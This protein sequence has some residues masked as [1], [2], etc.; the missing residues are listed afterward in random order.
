MQA[1]LTATKRRVGTA[2]RSGIVFL[3]PALFSACGAAKLGGSGSSQGTVALVVENRGFADVN[4]YVVRSEGARGVRLGTVNGGATVT[5]K[6]R[7]TYLQAGALMQL[8]ARAI[9]GRSSWTS[10]IISVS[11]GGVV[12]LE[13]I[14]TGAT[15][16][17]R[18]QFYII[19]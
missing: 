3:T 8:Q 1:M 13:L 17:S 10:P 4:L 14:A 18:S 15:D 16:L 11:M 5:F 9:G 12:K 19:Q 2:V 6:V 7:E